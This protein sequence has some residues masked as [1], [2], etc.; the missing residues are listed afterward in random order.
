MV[1][2]F[3]EFF[4]YFFLQDFFRILK[5]GQKKCPKI[6]IPKK[7]W[8]FEKYSILYNKFKNILKDFYIQKYIFYYIK[9]KAN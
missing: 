9:L 7:S 4:Y 3:S 5:N 2:N 6:K 1:T 8:N